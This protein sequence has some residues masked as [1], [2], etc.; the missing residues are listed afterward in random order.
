MMLRA[1][2]L[3]ILIAVFF[4]CMEILHILHNINAYFYQVLAIISNG[5][6]HTLVLASMCTP[7]IYLCYIA[8]N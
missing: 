8:I 3:F 5:I 4:H 2:S 1:A 7:Y 6:S